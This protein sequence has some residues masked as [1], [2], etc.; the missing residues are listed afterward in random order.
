MAPPPNES[1]KTAEI[2][3]N[4]AGMDVAIAPAMNAVA[5]NVKIVW[6]IADRADSI[7][8][9][10]SPVARSGRE[11]WTR[12]GVAWEAPDGSI[13]ARLDAV[14]MSGRISIR[15]WAEASRD[16]EGGAP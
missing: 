1:A 4:G 11:R 12:V 6:A 7:S 16:E 2:S 9:G 5:G 14:P 15:A 13:E 3:S 8:R 10:V